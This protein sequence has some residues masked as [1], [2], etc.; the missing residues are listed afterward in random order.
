[1]YPIAPILP[2][3]SHLDGS[4]L[5]PEELGVACVTFGWDRPS[6]DGI[7]LWATR[8]S[9]DDTRLILDTITT[10][11]TLLCHLDGDDD[12]EPD[13]LVVASVLRRRFDAN[14]AACAEVLS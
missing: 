13:A 10:P 3:L 6:D 5:T 4:D 12:Y 7:G 14:F 8:R 11:T 1:M 9:A 2:L